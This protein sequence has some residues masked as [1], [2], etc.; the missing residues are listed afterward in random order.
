MVCVLSQLG[1]VD[2][3]SRVKFLEIALVLRRATEVHELALRTPPTY[4]RSAQC[5]DEGGVRGRAVAINYGSTTRLLNL[6]TR[7]SQVPAMSGT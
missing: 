4:G 6:Y 3:S 7:T 5:A 2:R 1:K